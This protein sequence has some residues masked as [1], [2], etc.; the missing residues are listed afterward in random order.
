MK[1]NFNKLINGEK[2]VLIDF[3]ALWCGPCKSQSPIISE[4]AKKAK[5]KARVIK[6]DIDKNQAIAQRFKVMG[7]PTLMLFKNGQI[8]W[9]ESGVQSAVKLIGVIEEHA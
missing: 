2:P 3:H 6:I 8:V 5:G 1:G 4:V 9:R 7:V